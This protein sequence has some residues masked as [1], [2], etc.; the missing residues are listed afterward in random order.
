MRA[1]FHV[2]LC[3]CITRNFFIYAEDPIA[4]S[5]ETSSL[6]VVGDVFALL[7]TNYS[8]E[9]GVLVSLK[10]GTWIV[11]S[12]FGLVIG[13]Q[14]VHH[15]IL[16]DGMNLTMFSENKGTWMVMFWPV[17]KCLQATLCV[18]RMQCIDA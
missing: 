11:F 18:D 9:S 2:V 1:H 13:R 16:R 3:D 10:V 5:H 15:K 12:L 7:F 4:H 17:V 14:I 8:G 6:P